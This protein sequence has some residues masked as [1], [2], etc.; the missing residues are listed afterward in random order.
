MWGL[1]L[2]SEG[3]IAK[4]S[5]KLNSTARLPQRFHHHRRA[6][7]QHLGQPGH[8]VGGVVAHADD[9]IGTQLPRVLDH[10]AVGFLAGLFAQFGVDGDV[11]AEQGLDAA[12][13]V[14]DDRA[15]AHGDATYHAQVA[16]H[17]VA[18]QL[19]GGGDQR[20]V[21]AQR[22]RG[23]DAAVVGVC[24]GRVRVVESSLLDSTTQ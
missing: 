24:H 2:L 22:R 12:Q 15:R 16:R 1:W 13:E 17:T 23:G 4:Q 19:E 3:G 14:A 8:H 20:I 9:R 21:E 6:I 10:V 11:A 7:A 5:S 18:G